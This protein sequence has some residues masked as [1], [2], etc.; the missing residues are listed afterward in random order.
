MPKS[1]LAY[2]RQVARQKERRKAVLGRQCKWCMISDEEA[3]EFNTEDECNACNRNR[4]RHPCEKC[5][6]PKGLMGCVRC[7]EKPEGAF[8]VYVI[9]PTDDRERVIWRGPHSHLVLQYECFVST[10][11]AWRRFRR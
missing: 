5:K 4:F 11:Y 1:P 10:E 7:D 2:A 9:S 6:G 3:A 8:E